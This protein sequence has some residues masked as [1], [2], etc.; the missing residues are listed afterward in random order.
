LLLLSLLIVD[1][2]PVF[3]YRSLVPCCVTTPQPQQFAL[4]TTKENIMLKRLTLKLAT[5]FVLVIALTSVASAPAASAKGGV[6]CVDAP[7]DSD[8]TVYMCCNEY[9]NCWCSY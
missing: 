6:F 1:T 3:A 8:C 5:L 9:G 2:L 7:L 4:L